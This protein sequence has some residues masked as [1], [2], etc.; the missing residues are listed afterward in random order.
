MPFNFFGDGGLN[1]YY[2]R[3][4]ANNSYY[5]EQGHERFFEARNLLK[6]IQMQ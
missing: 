2:Y 1:V 5:Q 6:E 4:F 3:T